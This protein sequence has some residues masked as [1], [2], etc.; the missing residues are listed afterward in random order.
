[1]NINKTNIIGFVR[2]YPY[3]FVVMSLLIGGVYKIPSLLF[4][5]V[6][7]IGSSMIN[8]KFTKPLVL[9]VCKYFTLETL[10]LRPK[11]ANNCGPFIDE[12]RPKLSS[13]SY[14][15]PSGH[16]LEAMLISFF[17][18]MYVHKHSEKGIQTNIL[19]VTIFLMGLSICIS[20]VVLGCHTI[21]QIIIGGLLGSIIGY[22]GF[23]LW[24]TTLQPIFMNTNDTQT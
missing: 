16:S 7:I 15:M 1:M 22:Y 2:A 9:Q 18:I 4:L 24:E 17:L 8:S 11:G 6:L 20:R 3:F 19:I 12:N 5:V 23:I 10:A 21:L 13:T 14:G